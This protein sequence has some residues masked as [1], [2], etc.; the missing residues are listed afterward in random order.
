M[1]IT[2]NLIRSSFVLEVFSIN[3]FMFANFVVRTAI[4]IRMKF[5]KEIRN[6]QK[7]LHRTVFLK[8]LPLMLVVLLVVFF[9][10]LLVL[11]HII[12]LRPEVRYVNPICE[13]WT[14]L[15][16]PRFSGFSHP[17]FFHRFLYQ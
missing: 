3:S 7:I 2:K 4:F 9:P 10:I 5:K 16:S 15:L 1:I 17:I 11:T 14:C 6:Q 8:F 13:F 12:M